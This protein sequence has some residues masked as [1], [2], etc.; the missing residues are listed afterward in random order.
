ME[1]QT[2]VNESLQLDVLIK[3][4]LADIDTRKGEL[5]EL[6]TM[7]KDATGNDADFQALQT[8][9]QELARKRKV[10]QDKILQMPALQEA[11]AKIEDAKDDMKRMTETLNGYLERYVTESGSRTIEDNKGDLL[12]I[13]PAYK[14]KKPEKR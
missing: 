7:L 5:R 2:A 13:I 8:Q 10:I 9:S 1:D 14:I 3:K 12:E 11:K 6:Q 4:Y